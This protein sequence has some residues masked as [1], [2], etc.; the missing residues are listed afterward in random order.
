MNMPVLEHNVP[1]QTLTVHIC[2]RESSNTVIR[3]FRSKCG[4]T[5]EVHVT[6]RSGYIRTIKPLDVCQVN[7]MD[8]QD[9]MRSIRELIAREHQNY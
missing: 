2:E 4:N 3:K 5:L 9:R 1:F 7:C 6:S 8:C